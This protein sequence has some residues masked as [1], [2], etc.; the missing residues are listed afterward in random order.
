[1]TK[2]GRAVAPSNIAVQ[3]VASESMATIICLCTKVRML[4]HCSSQC[5]ARSC[6]VNYCSL[7]FFW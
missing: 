6:Q 1:M 3:R 2:G 4:I 7:P 5:R